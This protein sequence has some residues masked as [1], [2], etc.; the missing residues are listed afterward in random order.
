MD[1]DFRIENYL[2]WVENGAILNENVTSLTLGNSNIRELTDRINNLPNLISIILAGNKYITAIP[3]SVASLN[4]L[5]L[6]DLNR[7]SIS[8]LPEELRN[9]EQ[10]IIIRVEETPLFKNP[11]AQLLTWP[12]NITFEPRLLG[13][14]QI[15]S[16]RDRLANKDSF[17]YDDYLE[18]ISI[19]S[20]I[21]NNILELK[22]EPTN[23]NPERINEITDQIGNLKK[24][25][26]LTIN[27]M[28]IIELPS[29]IGTLTKLET[30][31]IHNTPLQSLP[32]EI[33]ALKKL[34]FLNLENNTSL[35]TL[36]PSI[37]ALKNLHVLNLIDTGVESL[38]ETLR[39]IRR[40]VI[41]AINRTPMISNPAYVLY[42]RSWERRFKIN[43]LPEPP[44]S[45]T[46]LATVRGQLNPYVNATDFLNLI[47]DDPA[48]K[49][50]N[51]GYKIFLCNGL[52]FATDVAT[53]LGFITN[54]NENENE[55]DYYICNRLTNGG[56]QRT[57][58]NPLVSINIITSFHGFVKKAQLITAL[59]SPNNYFELSK[60]SQN[61]AVIKGSINSNAYSIC[62][63]TDVKLYEIKVIDVIDRTELMSNLK[64]KTDYSD[65][66]TD[67]KSEKG[68]DSENGSDNEKGS[69]SEKEDENFND[70]VSVDSDNENGN[71]NS[72]GGRTRR[73]RKTGIRKSRKSK[74]SRKSR[75][76]GKTSSRKSRRR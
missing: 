72:K 2:Q 61:I 54:E 4:K 51:N 40:S 10:N 67:I 42:L 14:L 60:Q 52:Y 32:T 5:I 63:E 34:K 68:S 75:K 21:L 35:V 6:L 8:T 15:N 65:I 23:L 56:F 71:S 58:T 20:P 37:G 55:N 76:I 13:P 38:P 28:Y 27:D 17:N 11:P 25:D 53:I 74:K 30:I 45:S 49:F 26:S 69:D 19:G 22:L 50:L 33:G 41:I 73:I 29:T 16:I 48:Q 7:T 24:L 46:P 43:P 36:P 66:F 44:A 31:D 64:V 18:W 1:T 39:D 9:F 62:K 3:S 57:N 70:F 59:N 12:A 47:Y